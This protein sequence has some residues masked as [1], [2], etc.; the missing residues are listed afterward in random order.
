MTSLASTA[1]APAFTAPHIEYG[2]LSPILLIFGLAVGPYALS[3]SRFTEHER[4][5]GVLRALRAGGEVEVYLP[6]FKILGTLDLKKTLQA[7]G[8][9]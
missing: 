8:M 1:A 9:K 3:L 2:Q 4:L 7:M 6:R 5:F